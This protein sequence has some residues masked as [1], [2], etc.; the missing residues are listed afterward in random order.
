MRHGLT[1][2]KAGVF[3]RLVDMLAHATDTPVANVPCKRHGLHIT[4]EHP[5]GTLRVLHD[6]KGNPVYKKHMY[7]D[8]GYFNKTKG[9]DGDEVDCIVGPMQDAPEVY[10]VHM[11]DKGPVPKERED[12]DK[13]MVGF[14]SPDV[15][16]KAF[17]MHYPQEFYG[18]MTA[19]PVAEF[20]RKLATAQLPYRKKKLTAG[21]LR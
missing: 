15:A 8:Y 5:K 10:I 12:E 19:L 16:K 3:M 21:G 9:R 14:P 13:C 7:N 17:L 1:N 4:I 6:D 11:L 2:V 18:G 20:K